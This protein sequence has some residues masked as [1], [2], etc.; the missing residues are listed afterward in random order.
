MTTQ[1]S[2]P[3]Q[4]L[5]SGTWFILLIQVFSTMSFAVLYASL[6]LYMTQ[7]LG[8]T[9]RQANT[10]TGVYFAYNFALHLLSGYLAGRLFSYRSLIA[11]GLVFQLIGC[12]VLALDTMSSLYWGLS[13]MLVGT[14]TM[15][16][17]INMLVSQLYDDRKDPRRE[18][19]FMIN[20]SAMNIGFFLGFTI[21]GYF[22]L[23]QNF[24]Q[25]FFITAFANFFTLFIMA[26]G[27]RKLRDKAT[28]FIKA[29]PVGRW[30]RL[31]LGYGLV[32]VLVPSLTILLRHEQLSDVIVLVAGVAM[33]ITIIVLANRQQA[34]K[35][36]RFLLFMF[37]LLIAQV[38]W[39][40]YQLAP[41][42]FTLFAQY[43]VNRQVFGIT[44]APGWIQNINSF[45]IILSGPLLAW[46][47]RLLQRRKKNPSIP[48][49][50][51]IGVGSASIGLLL[52]PLGIAFANPATGLI[53]FVWLFFC[54]VLQ[55]LAEV[56][57]SPIGYSMVGKLVPGRYQSQMM[58]VVLLNSG[59]AAVLASYFSNYAL[60]KETNNNPLVTNAN[61]SHAFLQLGILAAVV[62]IVLLLMLP[63]I[64]KW[65]YAHRARGNAAK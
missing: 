15:V 2:A 9:N 5:P 25:L 56:L 57:I 41:M 26:L 47:F 14:G 40:I 39:V 60:G 13:C 22:Q 50:Y 45:T 7:K 64:K 11:T 24:N 34:E 29:T 28:D 51:A 1:Q 16:T 23:N 3:M 8:F 18:T 36:R 43:N 38:F 46:V 17:C 27:W 19:S 32:F 33:L 30:R 59:V 52:L 63:A 54:Y 37:L 31:A 53:A 6:V 58:G 35:R 4:A 20:Y 48:M 62:A 12:M 44:I 65:L 49:K 42:A 55:A 10:L 61:Y 21:S